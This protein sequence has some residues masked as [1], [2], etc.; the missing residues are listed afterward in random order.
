MKRC[1]VCQ[2]SKRKFDKP[3]PTLHPIPVSD[4]WNKVGIDLIQL[5]ESSRGNRYCITLTDYFSKWIEAAPL[6]TKEAKHVAAFLYSMIL[7]HGCPQ[8]IVS[9]Q[10]REFCNHLVDE[11]EERTGFQ[12]KV[13]SAY[14]PQSNGLDERTNQT[15]KCQFQKLV[16]EHMDDWD[17]LL[18]NILFAYRLSH[19]DST[20]CMPFMLMYGRE[21]RL[22]IDLTR[23]HED[24]EEMDLETKVEKMLELREKLHDQAHEN[25]QKA[26]QRQKK[27]YDEK[28]N[29]KTK[30]KLGD[31]VLV[32]SMK[33]SGRKGGQ[34]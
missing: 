22:P 24:E 10:G 25:A 28:H 4:T 23:V 5:P 19:Q 8:E 9:D 16:N 11:L 21:A 18:E 2:R 12:H 1:E 34:A 17:Q 29:T 7:R 14:H 32:K 30:L 15:L 31:K 20:K 26:Q 3:S 33:N 27:Q 6:P 13:T